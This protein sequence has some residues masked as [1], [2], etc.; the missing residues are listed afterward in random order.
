MYTANTMSSA[1]EA[2]GLSLPYSSSNPALSIEKKEECMNVGKYLRILLK[3]DIKPFIFVFSST[4]RNFQV[5]FY[6]F[7]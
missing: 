6:S 7:P 2:L 3:K 1:I 4:E 5:F